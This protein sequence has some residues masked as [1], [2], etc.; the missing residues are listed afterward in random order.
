MKTTWRQ[1]HATVSTWLTQAERERA[2]QKALDDGEPL[3]KWVRLL[4]LER[5]MEQS[6]ET[7]RLGA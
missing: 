4:I 1:A 7:E 5:L 3:S 2:A 6:N